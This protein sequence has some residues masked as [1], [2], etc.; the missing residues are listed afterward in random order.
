MN[1]AAGFP[2]GFHQGPRGT[3]L[4]KRVGQTCLQTTANRRR[5]AIY[6]DT[7]YDNSNHKFDKANISRGGGDKIIIGLLIPDDP[8]PDYPK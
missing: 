3:S 6:N 8:Y 4:A 5:N 1:I 2:N 7:D